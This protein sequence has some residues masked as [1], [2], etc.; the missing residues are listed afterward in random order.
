VSTAIH[1]FQSIYRR[2]RPRVLRYVTRL[3]GEAD[4]QDVTQ[5]VMLKLNEGISGFR[6]RSDVSTWIYRVA[7]NAAFD[8]LRR[9]T[10]Q[11]VSYNELESDS[12]NA[13]PEAQIESVETT[14]IRAETSAC[15]DDFIA[16][17]PGNYK[18]V[19]ILSDL[20]GFKNDEVATI[21]GVSLDTVKMRLHRAREKLR[22]ALRAGCDFSRDASNEPTC[23]RKPVRPIRF[24]PRR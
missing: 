23:D 20:A 5:S 21:L 6:G 13:L 1:D 9:S 17:L 11:T 3:V 7:T 22:N 12:E 8:H 14:A 19:I 15:I 4:A 18:A 10:Q 2:F 24:R 16:L